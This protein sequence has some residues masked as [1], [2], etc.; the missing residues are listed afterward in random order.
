MPA[1]APLHR[2]RVLLVDE[3]DHAALAVSA[4][5]TAQG[6]EPVHAAHALAGLTELAAGR[7]DLVLVDLDLSGIDGLTLIG[8]LPGRN[9][10][11]PV[12][13]MSRQPSAGLAGR[14]RAAG[15]AGLLPKPVTAASLRRALQ[16]AGVA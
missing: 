9:V 10:S 1:V 16:Q 8:L 14:V 12:L 6:W 13:A 15:G 7:F 11:A 4:L 3:D 2:G 5:L